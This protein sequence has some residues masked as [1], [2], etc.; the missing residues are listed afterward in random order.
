MRQTGIRGLHPL[1]RRW[2][3]GAA[4]RADDRMWSGWNS[5][6]HRGQR[7]MKHYAGLDSQDS[8]SWAIKSVKLRL[9]MW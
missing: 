9:M 4:L 3:G 5:H 2:C 6:K 7:S 1:L 8:A